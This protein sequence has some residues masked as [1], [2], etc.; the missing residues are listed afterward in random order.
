MQY[1]KPNLNLGLD[2]WQSHHQPIL[3]ENKDFS[4]KDLPMF[5]QTSTK[6]MRETEKVLYK[7]KK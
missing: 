5:Q 4:F 1:K 6:G 7:K 3:Q 2:F